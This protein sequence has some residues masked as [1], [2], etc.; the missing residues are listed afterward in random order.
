MV[1]WPKQ[2]T[3]GK[4]ETNSAARNLA[5]ANEMHRDAE[6]DENA[7]PDEAKS[8]WDRNLAE[9]SKAEGFTWGLSQGRDQCRTRL[10]RSKTR[11]GF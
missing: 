6:L 1:Y 9:W 11:N 7:E 4:V 5:A 2:I 8:S 10:Q 3:Q